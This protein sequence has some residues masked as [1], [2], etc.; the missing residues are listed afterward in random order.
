MS[1]GTVDV[2]PQA[3]QRS[4]RFGSQLLLAQAWAGPGGWQVT[5]LLGMA[6]RHRQDAAFD[7]RDG[8]DA[9][10]RIG[11]RQTTSLDGVLGLRLDFDGQ[12]GAGKRGWRVAIEAQGGPSL[13][14][15]AGQRVAQ[16]AAAPGARFELAAPDDGGFGYDAGLNV[17]HR[18]RNAIFR[19]SGYLSREDG[20]PDRGV[21]INWSRAF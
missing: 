21:T 3:D 16:F 12:N 11:A 19:L 20:V 7:E 6:L 18:D 8:G 14:R 9:A 2:R 15:R 10:L 5:P 1:Y 4:D 17:S 13:F